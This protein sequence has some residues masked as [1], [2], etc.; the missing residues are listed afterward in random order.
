[1]H[2]TA[3]HLLVAATDQILNFYTTDYSLMKQL[4]FSE[5]QEAN[6]DQILILQA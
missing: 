6:V 5:L 4:S 3:Q 1:M 2:A